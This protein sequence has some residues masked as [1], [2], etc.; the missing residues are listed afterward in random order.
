MRIIHYS[1]CNLGSTE[2]S[3]A[4]VMEFAEGLARRGHRV[5]VVSPRKGNLYPYP[6]A[7]E[8]TYVPIIKR[9]GLRQLSAVFFGFFTLIWLKLTWRPDCLYIRRLTLDPLPGIFAWLTRTPLVTETNGQV[10][11][12]R[13]EIP[14]PRLWDR[15]WY[16]L[17]LLFERVLF[18]NS[19]VV[20]ADGDRRLAVFR[21]RYPLIEGRFRMVR[22]G[23]I[24]LDRFRPTDKASARARLGL[25]ADRRVLVWVGTIFAW[26]GLEVLLEAARIVGEREADVCW[27]IIGDGPGR[28]S[29]EAL[30]HRL[31]IAER[32]RFAGYVP[33]RELPLWL[34]AADAA[35]APYTRLRLGREDFTSYK[36]FEYLA[37]G[38]PVVCSNDNGSSNIN[39]VAAHQL[40]VTVAPEDAPALAE[41][42][43]KVLDDGRFNGEGF[44]RRARGLLGELDLTWDS[45]V[46][47]VEAICGEAAATSSRRVRSQKLTAPEFQDTKSNRRNG[48]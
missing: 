23:G 46:D 18:T 24:D 36:I 5:R 47:R 34:A 22:S 43:S 39:L 37:C 21:R 8:M 45:L 28:G 4:H 29:Y 30:A 10:E 1:H 7:C 42:V 31:G 32:V 38:L 11:I 40:G 12:H 44:S 3:T 15:F 13:H 41:A 14:Q 17:L 19:Q 2:A 25:S 27:L 33:N 48:T 35:L 26:S 9:K 16:P 20:T 6:T